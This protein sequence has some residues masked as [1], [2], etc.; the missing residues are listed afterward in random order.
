[1]KIIKFIIG[2]M[3]I[4]AT[5]MICSIDADNSPLSHVLMI[6]AAWLFLAFLVH[7]IDWNNN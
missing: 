4:F 3:W 2:F 7:I 5:M 6:V 1:M